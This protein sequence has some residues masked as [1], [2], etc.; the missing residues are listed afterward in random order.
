VP[1]E[2]QETAHDPPSGLR[3]RHGLGHT[4]AAKKRLQDATSGFALGCEQGRP[5]YD[6]TTMAEVVL[7]HVDKIYEGRAKVVD[8]F[9]LSI[10]DGEFIV[11]V[12]PSGCGKSTTLRII[13]G[14]EV[15]SGGT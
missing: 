8:D 13:A 15:I 10:E 6:P 5:H 3:C 14:L 11:L 1:R 12:G 2:T 9:N 4:M 7:K